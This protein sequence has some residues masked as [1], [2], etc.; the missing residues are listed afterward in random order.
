MKKLGSYN[1]THNFLLP[2]PSLY[3]VNASFV[4]LH[5]FRVTWHVVNS[6]RNPQPSYIAPSTHSTAL[7]PMTPINAES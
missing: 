6:S 1:S 3:K 5:L 4:C 2:H 7:K